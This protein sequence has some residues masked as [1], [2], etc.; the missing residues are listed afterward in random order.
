MESSKGSADSNSA[1]SFPACHTKAVFAFPAGFQFAGVRHKRMSS[2]MTHEACLAHL[3]L[4]NVLDRTE[5][6]LQWL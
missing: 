6:A 5:L 3:E 1:K 4:G 2:T